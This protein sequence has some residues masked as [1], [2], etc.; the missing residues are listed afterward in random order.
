MAFRRITSMRNLFLAGTAGLFL[1]LGAAAAYAVPQN[2]PY[3]TMVPPDAVDGYVAGGPA[4]G[5]LGY[6]QGVDC[7][8]TGMIEGRSAFVDPEY[9]YGGS[10]YAD[11]GFGYYGA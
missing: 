5:C 4:Y 10:G 7:A 2:S 11:P 9:A 3:A 8:P 6:A 1:T